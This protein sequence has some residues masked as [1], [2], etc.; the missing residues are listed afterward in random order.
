LGRCNLL[1]D[2]M[3]ARQWFRV[4]TNKYNKVRLVYCVS[5][6]ESNEGKDPASA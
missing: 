5:V 3:L 4:M 2:K 6:D 1:K